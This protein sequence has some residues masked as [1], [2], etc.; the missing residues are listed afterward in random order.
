MR[1]T[2][3]RQ[4]AT[5]LP[6]VGRKGADA[7]LP[8]KPGTR[9]HGGGTGNTTITKGYSERW[10]KQGNKMVREITWTHMCSG[11]FDGSQW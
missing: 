4:S 3:D 2:R 5:L 9:L 11:G 10:V 6:D 8:G 1:G 7:K